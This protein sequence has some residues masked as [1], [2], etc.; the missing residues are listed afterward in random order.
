[1]K[2]KGIVENKTL[3]LKFPTEEIVPKKLI[4]H[5]I[6]GYFDGD[7]SLSY[8][9]RYGKTKTLRNYLLGFTGMEDVLQGILEY[10]NKTNIVIKPHNNAY[11]F[12]IGGNC[13][14]KNILN[15]LYKDAHVYLDRKKCIYDDYLKYVERQGVIG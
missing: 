9:T 12:N 2:E 8:W 6:R 10:F 7:G 3:K 15:L 14:L 11:E 5:F 4:N 13:Q 1:M